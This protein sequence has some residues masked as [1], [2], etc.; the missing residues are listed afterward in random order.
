MILLDKV[1]LFSCLTQAELDI[2]SRKITKKSYPKEHTIFYPLDRCNGLNF[3]LDGKVKLCKYSGDG[4]EQILSILGPGEI[5]GEVLVFDNSFY[6][7]HVISYVECT[8]GSIEKEVILELTK[9]N[10]SFTLIFFTELSKKI[11][12]LNDKIEYL[13]Y[14]NVKQRLA[15]F[16]LKLS[17]EQNS[18]QIRL[19][20]TKQHI[21]KIVGTSREVVSRN[22][23]AMEKEGYFKAEGRVLHLNINKLEGIL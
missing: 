13:S 15:K 14:P 22:F 5:F 21:S 2:L 4:C 3:V 17:K 6:P 16:L 11:R 23:S 19:K 12:I 7:V 18:C 9:T 10:S 8:L 20:H 1:K